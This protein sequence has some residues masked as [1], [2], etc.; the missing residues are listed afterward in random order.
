M[1]QPHAEYEYGGVARSHV[2]RTCHG[3][4]K[5]WRMLG[6]PDEDTI[7]LSELGLGVIAPMVQEVSMPCPD[8]RD[9][10]GKPTGVQ[11]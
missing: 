7:M 10:S 8:C 4:R 5:V 11:V 3:A 6:T 1:T 2:C 9:V